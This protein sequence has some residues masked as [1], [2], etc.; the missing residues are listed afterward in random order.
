MASNKPTLHASVMQHFGY[1]VLV[2]IQALTQP[3]VLGPGL[4]HTFQDP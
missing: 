4:R 1:P 3:F 2:T